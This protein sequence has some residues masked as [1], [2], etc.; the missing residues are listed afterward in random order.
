MNLL[1]VYFLLKFVGLIS[2]FIKFINIKLYSNC[3]RFSQTILTKIYLMYLIK[4]FIFESKRKYICLIIK[5]YKNS[6]YSDTSLE[7]RA[8]HGV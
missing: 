7:S 5:Y 4:W 8:M 2:I 3:K 6:Y 1:K